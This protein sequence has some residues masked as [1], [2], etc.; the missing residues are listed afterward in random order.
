[1]IHWIV[2]IF[3]IEQDKDLLVDKDAEGNA[4]RRK[5]RK[6]AE[7]CRLAFVGLLANKL[8]TAAAVS[9]GLAVVVVGCRLIAAAAAAAVNIVDR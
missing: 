7:H 5:P 3:H 6:L 2:I 1:M 4:A 9:I 8:A